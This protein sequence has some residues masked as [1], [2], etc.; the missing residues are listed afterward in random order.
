MLA[1]N[2]SVKGR[3]RFPDSGV[4]LFQDAGAVELS[5]VLQSGR[6]RRYSNEIFFREWRWMVVTNPLI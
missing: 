5:M 6:K 1:Y 4:G 3:L 2:S